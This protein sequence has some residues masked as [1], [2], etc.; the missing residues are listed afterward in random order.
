MLKEVFNI[1]LIIFI[2][3]FP[4]VFLNFCEDKR[5]IEICDNVCGNKWYISNSIECLDNRNICYCE[6][7]PG[8][9]EMISYPG[10]RCDGR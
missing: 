1:F 3:S 6:K 2:I 9:L 5:K 10:E 8:D 7:Y 4:I